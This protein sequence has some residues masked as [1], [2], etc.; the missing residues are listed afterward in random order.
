MLA[1]MQQACPREADM[2]AS[3]STDTAIIG[4]GNIG[5]AVAYYLVVHH[6]VTSIV[7]IDQG[8]PMAM[9]SAQSGENYRNWW[10]HPVM[11]AY[12]DH[13][14]DLLEEI[15]RQ[16]G[17]RI[18]MT[19]RGYVL[20]TRRVAPGRPD[21]RA[22][23]RLR[24]RCRK[25][26]P[27]ARRR[28]RPATSR[29]RT[30]TGR[31]RRTGWTCCWAAISCRT[32]PTL[33]SPRTS[34]RSCTSGGPATSADSSSA[35]VHAGAATAGMASSVHRAAV[36]GIDRGSRFALHLHGSGGPAAC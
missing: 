32:Q 20:A 5:L 7:L 1:S 30:A 24:R 18:N 13:A 23:P 19:R 10:P 14:T 12:T 6:G 2:Q 22:A 21:R 3:D 27:D 15:A 33:A 31:P 25:P 36:T 16:S 9:T 34:R 4:A 8:D 17:N 26:H 11:T 35:Q 29:R 28:R